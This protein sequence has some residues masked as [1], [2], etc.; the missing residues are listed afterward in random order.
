MEYGKT[1]LVEEDNTIYEIDLECVRRKEQETHRKM[2][3]KE[4]EQRNTRAAK[5]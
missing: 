3:K 1:K 2:T 5:H 4:R